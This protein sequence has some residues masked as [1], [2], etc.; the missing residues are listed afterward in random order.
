MVKIDKS[1]CVG[2]GLCTQICPEVFKL[3]EDDLKA[4]VVSEN[5]E[6]ECV[7]EAIDN[8]PTEAISE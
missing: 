5:S 1:K 7:K 3:S 4:E 6:A 2:C 8:C